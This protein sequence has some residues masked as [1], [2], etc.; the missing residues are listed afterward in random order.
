MALPEV[1]TLY[2]AHRH[3]ETDWL[4]FTLSL[5]RACM[6]ARLRGV[7]SIH[8]YRL[9]K[10]SALCLFLRRDEFEVLTLEKEKA[11]LI[12]ELQIVLVP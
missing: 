2:R 7:N 5:E 4:S 9:P 6:F 12:R 8:E 1:L 10:A 11:E 3:G